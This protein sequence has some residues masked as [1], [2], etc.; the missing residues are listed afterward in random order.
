MMRTFN[1]DQRRA[2]RDRGAFEYRISE[3][4]EQFWEALVHD[5][6]SLKRGLATLPPKSL[7]TILPFVNEERK[8]RG[9]K[10]IRLPK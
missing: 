5:T 4:G 10:P 6:A 2:K 7:A 3:F 8:A 1:P 9:L